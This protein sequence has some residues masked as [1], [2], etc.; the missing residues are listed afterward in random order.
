MIRSSTAFD[1]FVY[2]YAILRKKLRVCM[3]QI[4]IRHE[5]V[6]IQPR[7]FVTYCRHRWLKDGTQLITSQACDDTMVIRNTSRSNAN[8]ALFGESGYRAFS[9]RGATYISRC[10]DFPEMRTK[11]VLLSHCNC[12]R[13]VPEWAVRTAVA[14]L[15]PIKPFE[16][17][18]RINVGVCRARE[19]LERAEMKA[20]STPGTTKETPFDH[21]RSSRPAG[22]A[23]MGYACFWPKGG[24]LIDG[25]NQ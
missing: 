6:F 17:I 2:M 15:A 18:H 19:E 20:M 14:V 22:M 24:G 13:D 1:D 25:L 3:D 7:D 9:L 4:L 5:K 12:G 10:P 8:G 23:Q 21:R 11:L 16:I